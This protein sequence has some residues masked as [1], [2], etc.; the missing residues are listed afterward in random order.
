MDV[1]VQHC[2][3]CG[4]VWHGAVRVNVW[5]W[6]SSTAVFVVLCGTGL[7]GLMYGCGSPAL[8]CVARGCEG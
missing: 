1:T 3:V 6:Q 2:S 5:M 7:L 4:S 8:Q